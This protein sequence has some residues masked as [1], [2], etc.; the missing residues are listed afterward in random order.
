MASKNDTADLDALIKKL[1]AMLEVKNI[2]VKDQLAVAD[3]LIRA[4]TI[5]HRSSKKSK[6]PVYNPFAS[7]PEPPEE[8]HE[9]GR[10][11]HNSLFPARQ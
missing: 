7:E 6:G 11:F 9:N 2:T 4:L 1:Q 8:Q 3:R 10:D 5:R